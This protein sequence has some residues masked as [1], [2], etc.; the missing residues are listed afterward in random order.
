[1]TE[2]DRDDYWLSRSP[3]TDGE[4]RR[5]GRWVANHVIVPAQGVSATQAAEDWL[6]EVTNA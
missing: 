2:D 6:M 5:I 3:L 4:G 1:M